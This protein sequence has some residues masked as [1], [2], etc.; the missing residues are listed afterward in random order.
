MFYGVYEKMI[1]VGNCKVHRSLGLCMKQFC[2]SLS[3]RVFF[4]GNNW[5][6]LTQ[7]TQVYLHF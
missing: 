4:K 7:I 2:I 5:N 1:K 6:L 3:E